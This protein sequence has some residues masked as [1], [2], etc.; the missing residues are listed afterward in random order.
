[1]C[2]IIDN[3]VVHRILL[4]QDD[5]DFRDVSARLFGKSR[6]RAVVVYG[7]LLLEEYQL[8]REV[9][10]RLRALD[11]AGRARIVPFDLVQQETEAVQQS[12]LCV[13]N[14]AHVIALA[15][16]GKVRLLCSHDQALHQD[17][18]NK[19]LLDEPRGKVYQNRKHNRLLT[20]FCSRARD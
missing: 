7:G 13:S 11:Q 10:R 5:E 15:R 9:L 8:N 18:T 2:L 14:D 3:N 17:F 4:R 20:A 1:M 12:G 19:R 16:V 6:A